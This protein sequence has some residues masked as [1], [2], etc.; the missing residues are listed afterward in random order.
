MSGRCKSRTQQSNGRSSNSRRASVPDGA[1]TMSTSS[2]ASSSL[3]VC[4]SIALSS[5][6]SNR[7]T[8]GTTNRLMRSKH[9]SSPSVVAGL[10]M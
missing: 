8:R 3:T 7:F 4:A 5:T 9:C 6:T 2:C 1:V 10:T